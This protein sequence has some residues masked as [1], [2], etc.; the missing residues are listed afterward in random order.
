MEDVT[1]DSAMHEALRQYVPRWAYMAIQKYL[2]QNPAKTIRL[3]A[4]RTFVSVW[5]DGQLFYDC[6]RT[7]HPSENLFL[8][9]SL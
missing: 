1:Y 7:W 9:V 2:A 3:R 5:I 8:P 4:T 6:D